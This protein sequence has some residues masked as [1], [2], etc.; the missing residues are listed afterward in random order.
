M[1]PSAIFRHGIRKIILPNLFVNAFVSILIYSVFKSKGLWR[2][3]IICII[4]GP[5]VLEVLA[6]MGGALVTR[7]AD[8]EETY[9]RVTKVRSSTMFP[10]KLGFK[11]YFARS[12]LTEQIFN[13]FKLRLVLYIYPKNHSVN[14]CEDTTIFKKKCRTGAGQ[15]RVKE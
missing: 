12:N 6:D 5:G 14:I 1:A 9:P 13:G 7:M 11:S 8:G 3:L 2:I 4:G 10:Q 15:N